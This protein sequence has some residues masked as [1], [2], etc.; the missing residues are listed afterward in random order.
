ME[1][2]RA[3]S[4]KTDSNIEEAISNLFTLFITFLM[5]EEPKVQEPKKFPFGICHGCK[6]EIPKQE[7]TNNS[8]CHCAYRDGIPLNAFIGENK[9]IYCFHCALQE[10]GN[11]K[12]GPYNSVWKAEYRIIH[13]IKD[14]GNGCYCLIRYSSNKSRR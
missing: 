4:E 2:S 8:S 10:C 14:E 12:P 5:T 7:F 9:E 3:S 6:K 1:K 13:Q 11:N